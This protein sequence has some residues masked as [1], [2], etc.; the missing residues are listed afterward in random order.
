[1]ITYISIL[2]VN[3]F[4]CQFNWG[5]CIACYKLWMFPLQLLYDTFVLWSIKLSVNSFCR[6]LN[7]SFVT[8]QE[9]VPYSSAIVCNMYSTRREI[10][11]L[12]ITN[13]II[14]QN[15]YKWFWINLCDSCFMTVFPILRSLKK[16]CNLFLKIVVWD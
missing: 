1:M 6:L 11:L 16:G 10:H 13:F 14:V 15:K 3:K 12:I 5:K 9:L 8:F 2:S 4:N 7:A